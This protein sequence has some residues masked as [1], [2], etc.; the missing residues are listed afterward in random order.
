MA[1]YLCIGVFEGL[2]R[3]RESGERDITMQLKKNRGIVAV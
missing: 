2:E 3:G 1:S